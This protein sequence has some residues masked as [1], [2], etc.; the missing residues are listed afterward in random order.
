MAPDSSRKGRAELAR[1]GERTAEN[2]ARG[3]ACRPGTEPR[4]APQ[5]R[6]GE[7]AGVDGEREEE[8]ADDVGEYEREQQG[9]DAV[10]EYDDARL[11]KR[12]VC[13]PCG[14]MRVASL[15]GAC[16][17]AEQPAEYHGAAQQCGV[18]AAED[19]AQERER[20]QR[21]ER[22]REYCICNG[23]DSG[24]LHVT[25][26][27]AEQR[28]NPDDERDRDEHAGGNR[29][30]LFCGGDILRAEHAAEDVGARGVR[31]SVGEDKQEEVERREARVEREGKV[32]ARKHARVA[33]AVNQREARDE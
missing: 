18:G 24:P 20:H 5:D 14:G 11:E 28:E 27:R 23:R 29:D 4:E 17:G 2:Y 30:S 22:R 33:R 8:R 13:E 26:A 31:C 12:F 32:F 9:H 15:L 16:A 3:D 10:Q 7:G 1:E 19:D 25:E 21:D 6:H